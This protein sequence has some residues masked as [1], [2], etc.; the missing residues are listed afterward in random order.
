MVAPG[1]GS[2]REAR[3]FDQTYLSEKVHGKFVHRDYAA[4]F[5]RWGFAR[6]FCVDKR[7]LD[8]GCGPEI[9]LGRV[10]VHDGGKMGK[11]PRVY[12]GVDLSKLPTFQNAKIELHGE[13]DATQG[14]ARFGEFDVACCFEVVE[15]MERAD[16]VRLMEAVREAVVPGGVF[17]LSTPVR[18]AKQA[19][20]HVQ[21]YGAD[22]LRDMIEEAG[23][24]VSRRFGT[25]GNVAALR[26][27]ATAEERAVMDRLSE[28]YEDDV[29]ATFLAPLYPDACKN[30]LW[31][32]E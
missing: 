20:N 26:K 7:V 11:K 15:H 4:H 25:F 23:W 3:R 14:L 24:T 32:L 28:Y 21:E 31:V 12:V 29:L 19:R 18:Q 13:T 5:F 16:A 1:K 2:V 10:L 27:A 9:P 8:V 22:E 17:L 30:N 6:R